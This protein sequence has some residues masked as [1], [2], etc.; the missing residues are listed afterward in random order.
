MANVK[1]KG[2]IIKMTNFKDYDKYISVLT[3]DLGLISV[4]CKSIRRPKNRL[5]SFCQ[6][7]SF[8]EFELFY[9][10]ERYSLDDASSMQTFKAIQKDIYLLT[11]SSEIAEILLDNLPQ[12]D[13]FLDDFNFYEFLLR[14]LYEFEKG[15]KD[16]RFISNVAEFKLCCE[17]GYKPILDMCFY[18]KRDLSNNDDIVFFDVENARLY[19][20]QHAHDVISNRKSNSCYRISPALLA[21]IRYIVKSE[22]S[23]VF[24]FK[25]GDIV[26]QELGIF[27]KH[28]LSEHFTKNYDKL[29]ELDMFF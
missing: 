25:L 29:A 17:L 4:Y 13:K 9:N 3:Q 18:C 1:V 27:T 19:C 2:I 28:Y 26:L 14:C 15:E 22:S 8:N 6:L 21:A 16:P 5:N 7:F 24:S 11:A 10:K 20:V 12:G 23:K